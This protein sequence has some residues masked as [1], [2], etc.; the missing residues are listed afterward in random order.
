MLRI[1]R[2]E[3]CGANYAM[4]FGALCSAAFRC[5]FHFS[6]QEFEKQSIVEMISAVL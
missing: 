6:N 1:L 5:P 2:D 3:S 4:R